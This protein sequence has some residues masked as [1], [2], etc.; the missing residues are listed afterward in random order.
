MFRAI[1]ASLLLATATPASPASDDFVVYRINTKDPVVFITIDDGFTVSDVLA[2]QLE[3]IPH[4]NFVLAGP[5]SSHRSF[6]SHE[7]ANG[8]LFGNHTAKHR[9]LARLSESAQRREIC[10]GRNAVARVT[11]SAPTM[12]RPPFGAWSKKTTP[13]AARA[14]GMKHI[15]LWDVTA[16]R[17]DIRT[18]GNRGIQRGDIILLHFIPS[19][20][21]TLP[22]LLAHLD[23]L[24]LKPARLEDYLDQ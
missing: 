23:R 1:I 19:L 15:V 2:K 4:T 6:Y 9:N 20:S 5:L 14:C 16:D 12:L 18:W 22:K 24:H 10:A 13:Q 21:T 8:V 11:G 7:A 3:K 17:F